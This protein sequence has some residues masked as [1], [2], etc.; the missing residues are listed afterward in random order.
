M[1]N[2]LHR[3]GSLE[4]FRD[5][6]IVF[7]RSS[8]GRNESGSVP[9]LKAFLRT[10]LRHRPVTI[11]QYRYGSTVRPSDGLSPSVHWRRPVRDLTPEQVV[12]GITKDYTVAAIFDTAEAMEGFL[13]EVKA[14]GWGLSV[15]VAG[16]T[17]EVHTC[18]KRAGIARHS[19]EYSPGFQ[20]ALDRLP[21][22]PVLELS[23]MCGHGMVSPNLA[24]KMLDRVREG[25]RT[26]EQA[27]AYL[28]R[29]CSC[30]VFNP[31]RA[32]RLLEAVRAG[33]Y[34]AS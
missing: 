29:F 2:T 30:G 7:I 5:D 19:V 4:S 24:R 10:A 17:G 13:R 32:I 22:R 20:G 12:E 6:F 11:S 1:T 23:T 34:R 8:K 3:Y 21:E 28:G 14:A 33:K 26:P 25:H 15:N 31:A 9:K 16:L 27:T 18:A